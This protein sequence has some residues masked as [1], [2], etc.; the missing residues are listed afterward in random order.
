MKWLITGGCGFITDLLNEGGHHVCVLDNLTTVHPV[1]LA[2]LETYLPDQNPPS[3]YPEQG[4]ENSSFTVPKLP[5][6]RLSWLGLKFLLSVN[7][8]SKIGENTLHVI[9]KALMDGGYNDV[10]I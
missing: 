4:F 7:R 1:G 10:L 2:Q 6:N 8:R 5:P 3:E 9:G